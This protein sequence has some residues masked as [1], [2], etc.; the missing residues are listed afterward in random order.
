MSTITAP[1]HACSFPG[2]VYAVI[3]WRAE[4]R[5]RRLAVHDA[6]HLLQEVGFNPS[7]SSITT[8]DEDGISVRRPS[9]RRN[10]S[11]DIAELMSRRERSPCF[12][13][14]GDD[15]DT[16]GLEWDDSGWDRGQRGSASRAL[17]C[18]DSLR[19]SAPTCPARRRLSLGHHV[20]FADHVEFFGGDGREEAVTPV[21]PRRNAVAR[22]D[23]RDLD[24]SDDDD[25][26][27]EDAC[28]GNGDVTT[29][30]LPHDQ[31]SNASTDIRQTDECTQ[32]NQLRR[33]SSP[34]THAALATKIV[35]RRNTIAVATR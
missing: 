18:M 8:T 19:S 21:S 26:T 17:T 3:P 35:V 27:N 22:L 31:L 30:P 34:I 14:G 5:V 13:D 32:S 15:A 4:R 10:A 25:D 12:A 9:L 1:A 2:A 24:L 20:A 23:L 6:R 7:S 33:T 29:T 11:P 16:D 28:D